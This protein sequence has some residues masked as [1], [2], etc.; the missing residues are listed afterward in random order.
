M[1]ATSMT[2]SAGALLRCG[3]KSTIQHVV[4]AAT[5]HPVPI[6]ISC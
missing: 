3:I 1:A 2:M 6:P 5:W 4:M